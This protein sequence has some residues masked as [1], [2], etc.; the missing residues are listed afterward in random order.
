MGEE[1]PAE[2]AGI[3]LA[4]VSSVH[5]TPIPLHSHYRQVMEMRDPC[6]RA[7]AEYPS[8]SDFITSLLKDDG[9]R[10]GASDRGRSRHCIPQ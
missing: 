10:C 4:I 6:A 8:S 7:L 2:V 5:F 3:G 9:L 1:E